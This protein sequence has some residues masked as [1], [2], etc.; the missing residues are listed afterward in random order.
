MYGEVLSTLGVA[1]AVG[2]PPK[3]PQDPLFPKQAA[4][5]LQA[6]VSHGRRGLE[7]LRVHRYQHHSACTQHNLVSVV[8][9]V[10]VRVVQ[11]NL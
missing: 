7:Y 4:A 1:V 5:T 2:I 6:A 10:V 8:T 9:R 11:Q 3:A